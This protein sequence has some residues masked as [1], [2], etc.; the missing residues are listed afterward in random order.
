MYI[1]QVSYSLS[2]ETVHKKTFLKKW[3]KISVDVSIDSDESAN[4]AYDLAKQFAQEKLQE[5]IVAQDLI[6][7]DEI[8]TIQNRDR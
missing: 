4:K 3:E 5:S 7:Y 8:P 6:D 2:V 1:K